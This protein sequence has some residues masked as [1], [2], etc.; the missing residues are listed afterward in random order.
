MIDYITIKGRWGGKRRYPCVFVTVGSCKFRVVLESSNIWWSF[1]YGY[2]KHWEQEKR[3]GRNFKKDVAPKLEAAVYELLNFASD[4]TYVDEISFYESVQ[5]Y[6]KVLKN[7]YSRAHIIK[8][9]LTQYMNDSMP[10]FT[11]KFSPT[12]TLLGYTRKAIDLYQS[13]IECPEAFVANQCTYGRYTGLE[14]VRT[15]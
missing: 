2:K 3:N 11:H 1:C 13:W 7:K 12:I 14:F 9:H 6:E 8:K 4:G 15:S 10:R 5:N